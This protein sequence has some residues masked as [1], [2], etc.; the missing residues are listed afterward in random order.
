MK[1]LVT[2][3]SGVIGKSLVK[4]LL[5]RGLLIDATYNKNKVSN[6]PKSFINFIPYG[7]ILKSKGEKK[8]DQIWHFA[9]YGQPAKFMKSWKEVIKLN[10]YEISF[11]IKLLF[12]NILKLYFSLLE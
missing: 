5:N 2:G 9:T 10:I 4:N 1:I 6:S 3:G 8:Y 12:E 11:V 7:E